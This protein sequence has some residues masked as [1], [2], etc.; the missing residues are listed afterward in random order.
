M[1]EKKEI[2]LIPYAHLDTQ[3]RWEYPTTIKKY[4]KRTLEKNINLFVKYPEYR[5]NFTGAI[6]YAMMKEYYPEEFEKVKTYINED[7][8]YFIGT[9]L[10]ETDALI[11]SVESMIRNILYGDRWAMEEFGKSSRDYVIPDC[12]GFPSNMP[13]I[14]VHCGINGFSTQKLT[15][16]SAV[17]IP[18]EIGIW[19]G[20]DGS[21]LVCAFNPGAYNSH[22]LKPI[23]KNK[24]RLDKLKKLGEKNG[25]WKSYQYYGVGDIGG[26]PSEKSVLRAIESIKYAEE[27]NT[28]YSVRQGSSDQ[29]FSE[30]TEQ[31]KIKMDHYQ[32]DLLLI[33]HSAGILTSAA[34]M[35]RWNRKN[36]VLAFA[37]EV[38]AITALYVAGSPYPN[39]KIKSAWYKVIGNQMHDILPGTSTPI[40]Y[41]YS[42]NDEIVALNTWN[43]IL[44]DAALSIAPYVKGEGNILLFNPLGEFRND[45]IDIE[46]PNWDN[47]KGKNAEILNAEGKSL[48]VQIKKNDKGLFQATFIP[49]LLPL[50]WSRF[51]IKSG[52]GSKDL[53]IDDAVT[54]VSDEKGYRLE[55]SFYRILVSKDGIIESI[56]HKTLDK[57]LLKKPLAYELQKEKPSLFPAWNMDWN[58]RKKEPF[59]RIERGGEVSLVEEGPLRS[60]IRITTTYN[61]SK[62]VKEISLSKGSQVVNFTERINWKETGFS[63]KLALN[64]NMNKPDITYNWETS[65]IK[66]GLNHEKQ[67]EMP[68]RYWVDMSEDSW[69]ISIIEDSKYG[70]DHPHHDTLRMTL[71]YTPAI[72]DLRG[73]W[74]QKY[75]DWGEHTICYGIVGHEGDFRETDHLAKRLNQKIRSFNITNDLSSGPKYDISL[76]E[77]SSKQLGILA[78]KKAEDTE[79]ILLR[80]YERVGQSLNTELIFKSEIQSVKQVNGLEEFQKD[81]KFSGN[82]FAIN[83]EANEIHSYIIELKDR[84][85]LNSIKQESLKL[86]YN[87]KL[88]GDKKDNHAIFPTEITPAK[89]DSGAIL[90]NLAVDKELNALQCRGQ[91]ISIPQG[92]NTLSVLISSKEDGLTSFTWLDADGSQLNEVNHHIS[93]M[94]NY[95]GQWDTRT[96]KKKPKR[97]LKY[98]RDYVW[99]NKCTG[100]KPGYV[101]R[102]RLEWYATHTYKNG[103]I[104]PYH[105]GYFYTI[106]LEIPKNAK[107]LVLSNDPNIYIMAVT[108]SQQMIRIQNNQYLRDKFD[109]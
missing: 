38:A 74:D 97:H 30:I 19:K 20:P 66:R 59:L 60:T 108:A 10:D 61:S 27:N 65:R 81:I 90:Y 82:K 24:K 77:V 17:G 48:P 51:S 84:K 23:Y 57:E 13:T 79:G 32:G 106:N 2:L 36:E 37:A 12:F 28:W 47:S 107:S 1:T 98:K 31:E 73:F 85:K 41:E 70:Y 88:I 5:F 53:V 11:P 102:D 8:W 52:D 7:R 26:A 22:L 54:L 35:K 33:N 45:A 80:V 4:I 62:F 44:E 69:G 103:K 93:A 67:F 63:L 50:S 99:L 49:E 40:A 72:H 76:F 21:E 34:I 43:A 14:L 42:Q 56:L 75:Q 96:W 16:G 78:V 15:W 71:L 89:V 86:E 68:S 109:F 83:M 94:T 58:D 6:R 3:W 64:A 9:C 18:F 25:V 104:Q 100:V 87:S 39:D 105:Y 46:L 91:K 92:Y 95:L 101:K 55:N 29:F